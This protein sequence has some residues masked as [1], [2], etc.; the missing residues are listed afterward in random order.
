MTSNA[1]PQIGIP[2]SELTD[3]QLDVMYEHH[4]DQQCEEYLNEGGER[5]EPIPPEAPSELA[6]VDMRVFEG[7]PNVPGLIVIMTDDMVGIFH[8]N[9]VYEAYGFM[10]GVEETLGTT[11]RP[12]S[13]LEKSGY[14]KGKKYA[15]EVLLPGRKLALEQENIRNN[16]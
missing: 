7:D 4:V 16:W 6:V 9:C 11:I 15:E 13:Q 2:M 3:R 8:T 10:Y 5:E 14:D 12:Q 1:V